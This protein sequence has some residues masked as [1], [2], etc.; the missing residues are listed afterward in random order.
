LKLTN[1][2]ALWKNFKAS[3]KNAQ[4]K[5]T[6]IWRELLKKHFC[7]KLFA[8]KTS[9]FQKRFEI[10]FFKFL[11]VSSFSIFKREQ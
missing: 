8:N 1:I 9:D 2:F 7:K 3:N 11:K 10:K 6:E 4:P 5:E